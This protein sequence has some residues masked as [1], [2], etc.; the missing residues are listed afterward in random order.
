MGAPRGPAEGQDAAPAARGDRKMERAARK[1]GRRPYFILYF[2][3]KRS[4]RPAE[5]MTRCWPV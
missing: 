2:F 1:S 3:L 5:S 4:T